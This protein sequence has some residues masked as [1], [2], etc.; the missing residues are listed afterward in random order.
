MASLVGLF[1]MIYVE[2]IAD[3]FFLN[4][5]SSNAADSG[6]SDQRGIQQ[7]PA[8][9][10]ATFSSGLL[11]HQLSGGREP[12]H[13]PEVTVNPPQHIVE[14]RFVYSALFISRSLIMN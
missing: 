6:A 13:Q 5:G 3:C 7:H 4:A 2:K 11:K 10:G 9:R 14:Q 12:K 1:L 8:E